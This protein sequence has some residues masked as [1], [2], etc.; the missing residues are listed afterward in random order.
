M[1]N[2]HP[3]FRAHRARFLASKRIASKSSIAIDEILG[4]SRSGTSTPYLESSIPSTPLDTPSD[5]VDSSEQDDLKLQKL[6]TSTKSVMD[7]FKEKLLAK[8]NGASSS[9]TPISATSPSTPRDDDEDDYG[10]RPRGL[11]LGFARLG[12][13]AGVGSSK[14]R[15]EVTFAEAI[16]SDRIGI[17]MFSRLSTMVSSSTDDATK[18][19]VTVEAEAETVASVV[20]VADTTGLEKK[21]KK[22]KKEKKAKTKTKSEDRLDDEEKIKDNEKTLKK[23][24]KKD[25]QKAVAET[26][27]EDPGLEGSVV[28]ETTSTKVLSKTKKEKK[29]KRKADANADGEGEGTGAGEEEPRKKKKKKSSKQGDSELQ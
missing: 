24:R 26:L 9:S 18:A 5:E 20:E 1:L 13:G 21:R 15:S 3:R 12:L 4:I 10:D 16:E 2:I 7:Y 28:E 27:E 17:G 8:S 25:K 11:G 19:K 22:E 23:S 29:S 6:T 14:L